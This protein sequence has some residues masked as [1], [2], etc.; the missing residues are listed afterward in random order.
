MPEYDGDAEYSVA[1]GEALAHVV[2]CQ[3]CDWE[4]RRTRRE[5]AARSKRSHQKKTGHA[6]EVRNDGGPFDSEED[7]DE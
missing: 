5:S 2:D 3:E 4:N 1:R 6:V 7:A